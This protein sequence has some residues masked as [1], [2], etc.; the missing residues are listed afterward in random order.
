MAVIEKTLCPLCVDSP[1]RAGIHHAMAGRERDAPQEHFSIEPW[2][3]P[4]GGLDSEYCDRH[5]LVTLACHACGEVVAVVGVSRL[6][7]R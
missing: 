3:H 1:V 6:F 7:L 2:C 4:H 5:A